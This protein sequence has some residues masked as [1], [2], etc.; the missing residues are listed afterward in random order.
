MVLKPSR[1]CVKLGGKQ[2]PTFV[3]YVHHVAIEVE[4]TLSPPQLKSNVD[5]NSM[6][7]LFFLLR[8]TLLHQLSFL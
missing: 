8:E 1:K 2:Q 6:L 7:A 5:L 4:K 3:K